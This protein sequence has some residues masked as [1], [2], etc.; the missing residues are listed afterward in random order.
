M[1]APGGEASLAAAF[2]LGVL[3]SGHCVAMCGGIACALTVGLDERVRRSP[4]RMLPY[5]LAYNVGRIASYTVAGLAVG[6]AG[7]EA[8]K[9]V[10]AAWAREA[11]VVVS[12]AF[13]VAL[14]LYMADWWRGLAALE[15]AGALLWRRLEPL[16]RRLLPVTGLPGALGVGLVWG[17][18]PCGL[19]YAALALALASAGARDGALIMLAFG[20][21]TLPTLLALGF[22]GRWLAA[23]TRRPGLRRAAGV[24][25]FVL[26][27]VALG[28]GLAGGHGAHAPADGAHDRPGAHRAGGPAGASMTASTT[29]SLDVVKQRAELLVEHRA[30]HGI[31]A[32]LHGARHPVPVLGA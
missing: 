26:G 6:L 11:G 22:A 17:W 18:L 10:P 23:L 7:A 5:V 20:L 21:G 13:L 19:V 32:V 31:V 28:F 9:L 25:V 14:G 12:A 30:E 27:V 16:G 1:L 29:L 2:L 3:G 8:A 24:C 15:R 4:V